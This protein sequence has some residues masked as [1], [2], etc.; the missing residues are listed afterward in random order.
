MKINFNR[1]HKLVAKIDYID[2][3]SY[4]V[5][6][7]VKNKTSKMFFKSGICDIITEDGSETVFEEQ[8]YLVSF[9]GNDDFMETEDFLDLSEPDCMTFNGIGKILKEKCGITES[10]KIELLEEHSFNGE[11]EYY[12]IPELNE[13][14][15]KKYE[16]E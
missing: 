6:F 2:R 10:S 15:L 4:P 1:L 13:E 16:Y 8:Q 3:T 11:Y 9:D 14:L 5:Y 7:V 12:I